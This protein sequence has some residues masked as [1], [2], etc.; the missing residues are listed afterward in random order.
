MVDWSKAPWWANYAAMDCN[1]IWYWFQNK[2]IATEHGYWDRNGGY[3][4]PV[5]DKSIWQSTLQEKPHER[6]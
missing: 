1:G 6:P 2:P 3:V 5:L 4:Q